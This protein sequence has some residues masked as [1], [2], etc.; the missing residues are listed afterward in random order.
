MMQWKFVRARK[1]RNA[2]REILAWKAAVV[3]IAFRR[4]FY[5]HDFYLWKLLSDFLVKIGVGRYQQQRVEL[6]RR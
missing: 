2:D 6:K 3:E 1:I 5:F 4:S